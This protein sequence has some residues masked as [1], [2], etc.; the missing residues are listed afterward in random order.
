MIWPSAIRP[1]RIRPY[2][3]RSD[4]FK[5]GKENGI[6]VAIEKEEEEEEEGAI[7]KVDNHFFPSIG[8]HNCLIIVGI[9]LTQFFV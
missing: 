5:G 4:E 1:L 6:E 7:E 2:Q 3:Q 8:R 9:D